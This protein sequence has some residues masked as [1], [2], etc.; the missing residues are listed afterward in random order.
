LT[1]AFLQRR[2]APLYL[3]AGL[4]VL[5]AA[6]LGP[7]P[8]LASQYFSAHMAMHLAVVAIA[9]PLIA[10]SVAGTRADPVRVLPGVFAPVPASVAEFAAVWAWHAPA[11]HHAARH[12]LP[13]LVAEQG[14]FLLAGL[15]LWLAVLGG[16]PHVRL[17]RAA[18][19]V[20][21]LLLTSMHMTLLGALLAL[22]PRA[23]YSD[24]APGEG[25]SSLVHVTGPSGSWVS[26]VG[27][28]TPLQDQHLGGA[29]ML[30][31]GGSVYLAGGLWLMLGLVRTL[32]PMRERT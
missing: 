30:L 28:W 12:H 19:G 31:V 9:A 8:V 25:T 18:S 27:G 32:A 26:G 24:M 1:A 29:I 6:W 11:L 13:A 20:V 2:F 14:T 21:A 16:E 3:A 4:L 17:S 5:A 7:L 10:C 22:A 15:W 23:L